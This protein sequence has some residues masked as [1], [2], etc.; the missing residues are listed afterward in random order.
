MARV[1]VC[2]L[3]NIETTLRVDAF[4]VSYEPVHCAFDRVHSSISG[5]GFNIALALHTLG[6]EVILLSVVGRD[7][8]GELARRALAAAGLSAEGLINAANETAQS[9]ILYDAGGRR[10]NHKDL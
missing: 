2:G 9:V 5:V 8:A 7:P 1:V 10:A 6:H 3:I 4:P